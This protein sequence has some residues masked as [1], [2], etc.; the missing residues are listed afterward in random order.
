MF[1]VNNTTRNGFDIIEL[2]DLS[3]NTFA[4]IIPSCGGI[5]HS[6]SIWHQDRYVNVIDSYDSREDFELHVSAKGFKGCKM[7]PFACRIQ[8][9]AY[10]FEEH[11]YRLDKFLLHGSAMHG[12]LYDAPFTVTWQFA[13]EEHAGVAL[14]YRYRGECNGYP[15][16]YNCSITYHL[17]KNSELLITTDITNCDPEGRLIPMQDGWHPY[18]TLGG[19]ID[20]LLLKCKTNEKLLFD[21]AM[22]P[23]GRIEPYEEFIQPKKIGNTHFDDCFT[24]NHSGSQPLMVLRN[25]VTGLQVEIRPDKS[26]PYVQLYTP[27][28]R[29][30]IAIENLSAPP[31]SFNN[32]ISLIILPPDANAVFTTAYTIAVL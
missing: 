11:T 32:G 14:Q 10:Q 3:G 18:F 9:A 17:K 2:R 4:E 22:I 8:D 6:F 27:P 5:L 31:D 15:F 24:V 7:S 20:D 19:K 30:S 21:A 26:Y 1:A 13:N 28:H 23:T 16:H 29:N 25:A 12:L